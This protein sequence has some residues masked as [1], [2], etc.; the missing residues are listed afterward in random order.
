[1]NGLKSKTF[2]P[3]ASQGLGRGGLTLGIAAKKPMI[4]HN[5]R[6]KKPLLTLFIINFCVPPFIAMIFRA[7]A[8][9]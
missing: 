5:F 9:L 1:M 7:K 6:L 2:Y 8:I 4:F 3:L